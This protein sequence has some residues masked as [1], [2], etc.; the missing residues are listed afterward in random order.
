MNL[1]MKK[2]IFSFLLCCVALSVMSQKLA[3]MLDY[4]SYCTD[5]LEPYVEFNFLVDGQ[6]VRYLLNQNNRFQAQVEINVDIKQ[7]DSLVENMDFILLSDEFEDSIRQGKPDFLTIKNLKLDNGTYFIYFT[8]KDINTNFK[9]IHYEDLIELYFPNDKVSISGISLLSDIQ[10]SEEDH[11]YNKYGYI[12]TPLYFAY[13]SEKQS[14]LPFMIEIYNTDYVF[15]NNSSFLIRSRIEWYET[16]NTAY[17]QPVYYVSK[18]TG[19]VV[20]FLHQFNIYTL[21]SGNYNLVVEVLNEDSSVVAS[22]KVFFQRNNPSVTLEVAD[23][24]QINVERT[25][26]DEIKDPEILQQYVSYLYP[27]ATSAEQDFFKT[28]LKKVPHEKMQRYF[29]YFW[30]TRNAADPEGEWK[31]YKEKVDYVHRTYGSKV[32]KGYQ[33]DRGRVYLKY[34]KPTQVIEEPYDPQAYP[35]EIWTYYV[36]GSQTNVKFVFCD[37]DLATNDYELLHSDALGEVKNSRWQMELTK[38]LNP[39]LNPDI[40]TPDDYWGGDINN[41]WR[42]NR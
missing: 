2:I 18:T 33:T 30:L 23:F 24:N 36:L 16:G 15:G 6:S 34:G 41:N 5:K 35:Y 39:S 11:V 31:K 21:P 1:I 22:G 14:A 28:R 20:V 25:F 8:L 3:V 32:I 9:P 12:M 7:N 13:A 29:Y 4:K 19:P 26:V 37:K 40:K 38:R 42:L 10:E 17:G 27:I